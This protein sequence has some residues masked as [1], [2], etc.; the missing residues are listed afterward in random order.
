MFP[1]VFNLTLNTFDEVLTERLME[2]GLKRSQIY[3]WFFHDATTR[4]NYIEKFYYAIDLINKYT[5]NGKL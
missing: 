2:F 4:V 3:D 1:L 5:I